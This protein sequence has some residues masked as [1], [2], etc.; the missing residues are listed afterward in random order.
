FAQTSVP[1]PPLIGLLTRGQMALLVWTPFSG[2]ELSLLAVPFGL[3]VINL[4]VP[5]LLGM[6]IIVQTN[7]IKSLGYENGAQS[8]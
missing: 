4:A 5:A 7:V 8:S 1:L 6:A 3:F 2:S